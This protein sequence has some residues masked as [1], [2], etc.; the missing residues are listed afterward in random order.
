M[1][2]ITINNFLK[3]INILIKN[4]PIV[5][6]KKINNKIIQRNQYKYYLMYIKKLDEHENNKRKKANNLKYRPKFSIIVPVYNTNRKYLKLCIDSVLNQIYNNWELCVV[7]GG[8]TKSYIKRILND[9]AKK[10]NRIKVKFLK[11]NKG[12]ASNS[13]EALGI[14]TGE[15]VGFLDHDD[16]LSSDALYEVAKLLNENQ[17]LDLIYS[18]EDKITTKGKR[19]NPHFKPDW[20][21]DTLYSYNYITHF[22][23]MNRIII[24]KL[25]GFREGYDGAQDYD[26]LLRATEISNKIAHIP[27]ILYHWRMHKRSV[28][29]SSRS[30]PYA[31][32]A[33]KKAIKESLYRK[34]I[35]ADVLD[36]FFIGSYRVKY[37]IFNNPKVTIII[38]TKD[39]IEILKRCI[40]S[41]LEKT[42]YDNYEILIVDNKSVN[43]NT[44]KYYNEIKL[45]PKIKIISYNEPF[46]YSK[47]NNYA[48]KFVSSEYIIFLN[49]DIEVISKEWITAMLEH[50]QRKEI[51]IVGGLL[52]YPNN[53]IQHAGVI[54]GIGGFA[55]HSHRHF[56]RDAMGYM[57]RI[58]IIQN[59]SAVTGACL[60]TKKNIFNEIGGFDE[61]YSHALNDIDF[62]LKVREKGYLIIYTPYTELYHYESLTRGYE[63]TPEKLKRFRKEIEY[64][65]KKW[66]DILIKGDPYYNNNLTLEREDFSIKVYDA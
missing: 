59:L 65:R 46:N 25:G 66:K 34:K 30:K 47:I 15:F 56:L 10:D 6:L 16:E 52:Y 21:P 2:L 48:I 60:M 37:K 49:N 54:I 27:K 42:N 64:F 36:G 57:G 39:K 4:G 23:V 55:G 14:A 1:R 9:Y 29:F 51:G 53:T 35:E 40:K 62:C 32:E 43:S 18:D 38:P 8:S 33:A 22:L 24:N 50:I 20:S 63:E 44:F 45:N 17:D 31:Y 13:N 5:L 41:I 3:A 7:D 61:N 28:S 12:I 11:K 58:R 26:L 19:I